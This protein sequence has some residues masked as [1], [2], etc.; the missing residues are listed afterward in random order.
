MAEQNQP[1]QNQPG[2]PGQPWAAP[3]PPQPPGSWAAPPTGY[4]TPR[5]VPPPL[6][7]SVRVEPVPGTAFGVAYLGVPPLVAGQ[8]I[9]SLVVG[10]GSILV[11]I[12]VGCFGLVAASAQKSW[13]PLVGGAFAVLAA[14]LALAGIGLGLV[15]LRRIRHSAGE[16]TGRGLAIAGMVC[17]A[18]GLALTFLLLL[19][20]LL[21]AS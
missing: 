6:P 11:A 4:V 13:G 9:A 5:P 3:Y 1:G 14:L 20:A 2:W 8:A 15:G 21:L 19:V 16:V 17:A 18:A 12:V 10:I 7:A